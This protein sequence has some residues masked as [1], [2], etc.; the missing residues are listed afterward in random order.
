MM[1]GT[2]VMT[3]L[4]CQAFVR[5]EYLLKLATRITRLNVVALRGNPAH[6]GARL[7]AAKPHPGQ[8]QVAAWLRADLESETA[9]PQQR[10]QDRYSLR[11]APARAR[12]A[13]RQSGLAAAASS[14][15]N[16]TA[17]TITVIDPDSGEVMHGGH[18]YGGHIAFAM[19]SLKTSPPTSPTCSTASSRYW[20]TA[21]TT[22][23]YR[24]I[25]PAP[26]PSGR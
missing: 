16:S 5:A 24:A 25:S 12:S 19:D 6:F 11:C 14:R 23:G 4:A 17:P 3:A 8:G 26:R 15:P 9:A 22:T 20:S 7:F 18:F 21:A 1:N 2:A 13:G 10:L